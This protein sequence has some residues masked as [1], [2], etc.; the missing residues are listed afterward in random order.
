MR[1]SQVAAAN[2]RGDQFIRRSPALATMLGDP[3]AYRRLFND[4]SGWRGARNARL[5]VAHGFAGEEAEALIQRESTIRWIRWHWE[6]AQ[7]EGGRGR[8]A[9]S[10]ADLA[11][12]FF[13]CVLAGEY[14]VVDRNLSRWNSSFSLS[15]SRE[16]VQLLNL[17]ERRGGDVVLDNF[18]EFASSKKCNS[19]ALK[20]SL[21]A[22][23][24]RLSAAQAKSL[25]RAAAPTPK[26]LEVKISEAEG[27]PE[28]R[29]RT[30]QSRPP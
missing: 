2:V 29:W 16:M 3:D 7:E 6:Q 1:L 10:A 4:R 19:F 30:T 20:V 17:Y 14:G 12:V 5:T 24:N 27:E 11:A 9:P 15:V 23:Q 18:I 8:Q 22:R 28:R 25:T 21:L 26:Q 13:Q